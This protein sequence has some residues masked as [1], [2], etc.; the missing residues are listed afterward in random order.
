MRD[1]E[2]PVAGTLVIGYGNPLRGDDGVGWMAADRLD[3]ILDPGIRVLARHQLTPELAQDVSQ[4]ER[5]ILIDATTNPTRERISLDRIEPGELT[6]STSSHR[7]SPAELLSYARALYGHCPNT[8]LVSIRGESFA[9][10][11]TLSPPVAAALPQVTA[12]VCRLIER[13]YT[14]DW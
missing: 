13:P 5:L 12:L 9:C 1:E 14:R 11:D 8:T 3:G 4:V 2:R 6:A 10:S 7:L